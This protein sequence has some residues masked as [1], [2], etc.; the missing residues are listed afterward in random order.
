MSGENYCGQFQFASF[1]QSLLIQ[2]SLKWLPDLLSNLIPNPRIFGK[3]SMFVYV[4]PYVPADVQVKWKFNG[5]G[6]WGELPPSG[7]MRADEF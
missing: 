3:Y 4:L 6:E 7:W 1:Q 5:V 2:V